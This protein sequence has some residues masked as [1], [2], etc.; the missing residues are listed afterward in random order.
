MIFQIILN[1]YTMKKA[2]A[3]LC[4]VLMGFAL[5]AS[6]PKKVNLTYNKDTNE[7]SIQALHK[8]K[9]VNK[10]YIKALKIS[11][12][13]TEREIVEL[14]KQSNAVET[15]YNYKIGELKS[16]DV[17]RVVAVCNK[18]GSKSAELKIE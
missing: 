5:V 4:F 16:G 13:G 11:V 14:D 7:L 1:P 15:L 2:I 18:P 3:I 6:P 9:D 8:T 17:V 12:N 10:H